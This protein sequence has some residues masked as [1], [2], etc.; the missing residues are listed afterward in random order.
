MRVGCVTLLRFGGTLWLGTSVFFGSTRLFE[1]FE[2]LRGFVCAA[3][4]SFRVRVKDADLHRPWGRGV[5][6]LTSPSGGAAQSCVCPLGGLSSMRKGDDPRRCG[7]SVRLIMSKDRDPH[8]PPPFGCVY[9][10]GAASRQYAEAGIRLLF[11]RIPGI[12][13]I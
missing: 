5:L 11:E 4:V 12:L 1:T 13:Y 3:L 10:W 8:R 2:V 6:L 9:A 7:P